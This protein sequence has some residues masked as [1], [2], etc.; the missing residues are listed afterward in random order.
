[1]LQREQ[2][3]TL[4]PEI[5]PMGQIWACYRGNSWLP[6]D[7]RLVLRDRHGHVTEGTVGYLG[8]R[9]RSNGSDMGMLQREQ[10]VTMWPEAGPKGQI[11]RLV[12]Q[13]TDD[14]LGTSLWSQGT[15]IGLWCRKQMITMGP[16]A[17]PMEQIWT[18]DR[19][20]RVVGFNVLYDN[21]NLYISW[22]SLFS[23]EHT[24]KFSVRL[25]SV[26][27]RGSNHLSH[28]PRK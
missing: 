1:M 17:G 24:P 28:I 9:N 21:E 3:V 18:C 22:I 16:E 13:E 11:Y 7:Q 25:I 26:L 19:G 27:H 2:L 14:Y 6:W 15:N 8:T 20:N 10:L 23:L 12:T 5:G 4:G